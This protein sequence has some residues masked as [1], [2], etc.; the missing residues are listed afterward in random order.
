MT[1]APQDKASET[2][3]LPPPSFAHTLM[4]IP[5]KVSAGPQRTHPS[6]AVTALGRTRQKLGSIK[7]LPRGSVTKELNRHIDSF[8]EMR[9]D[10]D[11]LNKCN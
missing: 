7:P 3:T 1:G 11:H 2:H 4:I 8:R 6:D 10:G 9:A 5:R